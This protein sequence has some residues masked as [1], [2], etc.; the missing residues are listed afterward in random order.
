M[1]SKV[2]YTLVGL[3]MV[4]LTMVLIVGAIWLAGISNHKKYIT[5]LA[6]MNESVNG[7]TDNAPV[8][9]NGVSVGY[10]KAISLNDNN[11]NQVRLML[12][13]ESDAPIKIDTHATLMSQGLTGLSFVN[14]SGGSIAS[15]LLKAKPGKQ[16][17]I[18][19]TEA[20]FLLRVDG[21]IRQL[22]DTLTGLSTDV[23][24]IVDNENQQAFKKTLQNLDQ[25]TAMLAK[26]AKQIDASI[27]STQL[28]LKNTAQASQQLPKVIDN[29]NQASHATIVTMKDSHAFIQATSSQ[30]LP[31]AIQTLD[32]LQTLSR[33][34][35][36]LTGDFQQN[37]AMLVLGKQSAKSGPGE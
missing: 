35:K 22:T 27:K 8:K 19:K 33:Q 23:R 7:L 10:V 24:K 12:N 25:I 29:L 36:D 32:G 5:Y 14:L 34:L 13:I 9:F 31:Q 1:E 2:N 20:S 28:M 3:F 21:A 18:I 4:I 6:F 26:N 30:A 17:A 11:P 15:P 37:P 16:Y